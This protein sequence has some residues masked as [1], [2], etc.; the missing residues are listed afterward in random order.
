MGLNLALREKL[1]E[2]E[3]PSYAGLGGK[4]S[5][6]LRLA[7]EQ[8]EDVLNQANAQAAEVREQARR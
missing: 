6:M 5:E 4:A 1:A 2:N 8:A 7:E 3:T